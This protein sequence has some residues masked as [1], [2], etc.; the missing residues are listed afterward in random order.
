MQATF[1]QGLQHESN[2]LCQRQWLHLRVV[3]AYMRT[4]TNKLQ[5]LH[6]CQ[7]LIC[8]LPKL[9]TLIHYDEVLRHAK[10]HVHLLWVDRVF[11][12]SHHL[13]SIFQYEFP[14]LGPGHLTIIPI[15]IQP[16]QVSHQAHIHVQYPVY[17]LCEKLSFAPLF[18]APDSLLL[19]RKPRFK[20]VF[21]E[22]VHRLNQF[23]FPEAIVLLVGYP[24]ETL[25]KVEPVQVLYSVNL[26]IWLP[27]RRNHHPIDF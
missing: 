25:N 5:K 15:R 17:I 14:L 19:V 22:L 1:E 7:L 12:V 24:D 9:I 27:L 21:E 13:D 2:L 23:L 3:E 16:M 10:D 11:C 26:L 18:C 8:L 20:F 4:A 6:K